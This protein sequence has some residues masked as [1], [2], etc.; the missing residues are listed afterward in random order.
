M[1]KTKDCVFFSHF[2]PVIAGS[3]STAALAAS[4]HFPQV[5]RKVL[6]IPEDKHLAIGAAIGW[7][8]ES[9]VI[10]KFQRKRAPMQELVTWVS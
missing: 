10:N 5:A 8:D 7:P 4:V 3:A 9:A 6:P 2:A 1:F